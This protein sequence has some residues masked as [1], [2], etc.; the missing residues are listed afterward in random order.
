ML[1]LVDEGLAAIESKLADVVSTDV[2][3]L[4]EVSH[5][6]VGSGG[7]RL[8]A[9]LV[10]LAYLAAGGQDITGVISLAAAVELAHAATRV[11]DDINVYSLTQ[12]SKITAKARR[13]RMVTLLTGDYFFAKVYEL[14]APYGAPYDIIMA[15]ACTK[16]VEG[17]TLQAAAV[18]AGRIDRASYDEIIAR[19]TASLFEAA[20]RMGATLAAG[21][22]DVVSALSD[23]AY[24][25][26][27]TFQIMAD[28]TIIS[29]DLQ[30][31]D[32][33]I[34]RDPT[35]NGKSISGGIIA[36]YDEAD[37]L[38]EMIARLRDPS[39]VA[40]ALARATELGQRA[41]EALIPVPDSPPRTELVQ[42]V[43]SL[44]GRTL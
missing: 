39:A 25:L 10:L 38:K 2:D 21:D 20:A 13:G 24:N 23:F 33:T 44:F 3:L 5:H 17:E 26:G 36:A 42:L 41:R 34:D 4:Q 6:Y 8:R 43:D 14:M 12:L 30:I 40:L 7:E 18:K 9:R 32:K 15:N 1:K 16:L 37:L 29:G 22:E 11:H 27:L 19:K 35:P 28:I 31:S